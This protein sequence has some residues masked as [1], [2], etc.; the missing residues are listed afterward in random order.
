MGLIDFESESETNSKSSQKKF[1]SADATLL[2]SLEEPRFGDP[3]K[4]NTSDAFDKHA[5]LESAYLCPLRC[6]HTP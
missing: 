1:T 5:R 2:P 3:R 6:Q 4:R